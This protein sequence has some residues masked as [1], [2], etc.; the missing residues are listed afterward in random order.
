MNSSPVHPIALI[1]LREELRVGDY[2]SQ[3]FLEVVACR[4][5]ELPEVFV[6]SLESPIRFAKLLLAKLEL[7][8]ANFDH[9]FE[10]LRLARELDT[11]GSCGDREA[12]QEKSQTHDRWQE[13]ATLL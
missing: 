4:P 7:G 3:G 5:G 13:P 9:M 2:H 8:R 6:C 1:A 11:S 10:L 12:G